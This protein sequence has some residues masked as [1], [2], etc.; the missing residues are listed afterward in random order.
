MLSVL[1]SVVAALSTGAS[2]QVSV[3]GDGPLPDRVV[4]GFLD[5]SASER[6][7]TVNDGVM[8]GRS[9]GGPSFADGLMTFSGVTNTNGGGFSSIRTQPSEWAFGDA[10]GLLFR[11]RGDGRKY[12]AAVTT[13][14]RIGRWDVSYW[15]EFQ[16][17]GD[18]GWQTVA[19]PFASFVPTMFGEDVSGRVAALEPRDAETLGLYIY[20]KQDG[21]FRIDVAWIGVYSDGSEAPIESG[22]P[23]ASD[24]EASRRA[25]AV[26]EFAVERG[27]PRFNAGQQGACADIYEVAIRSLSLVSDGLDAGVVEALERGLDA[28]GREHE[29]TERAWIYRRA[30]DEAFTLLAGQMEPVATAE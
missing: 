1:M 30:M 16:T 29:P 25:L 17:S 22:T 11:V 19:L 20:D 6:W 14:T 18:G 5:A 2:P 23:A 15:A 3:G 9:S 10:D 7:I 12:I 8:G 28:G 4:V 24:Q 26:L 21:P 13:D 27:V